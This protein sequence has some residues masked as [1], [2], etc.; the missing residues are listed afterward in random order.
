MGLDHHYRSV[1]ENDESFPLAEKNAPVKSGW[2]KQSILLSLATGTLFVAVIA[3]VLATISSVVVSYKSSGTAT[4][5]SATVSADAALVTA[6]ATATS[7]NAA[8][9]TVLLGEDAKLP[10][11]NSVIPS[12]S[13]IEN[14]GYSP[15]EAREKG[16]IFDV[17]MQLWTPAACFD[18]VLSNRF[19]EV[20]N[21]TWYADPSAT[22]AYSLE[23]M[24]KGEHDAVYVAQDYHITHCIY[25]WEKLVR[26]MRN[27]E[28]LIMELISYDHVIHCRHKTLQRAD[29]G[30]TIRGVRAPT[31][32][33]QCAP[34]DT[35]KYHLPPNEHSSVD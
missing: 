30:A 7:A 28:P 5:A 13:S 17:M 31:G 16:C 12:A 14:C 34:Y 24:R 15:Q 19:L 23:E 29:G 8:L 2:G 27:Q 3:A 6:S 21:W 25:A 4:T 35:W 9:P 33:T 1:S 20:G 32:Y 10:T 18:E 22:K 11:D 26:A